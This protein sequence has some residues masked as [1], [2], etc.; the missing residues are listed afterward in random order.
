MRWNLPEE[1][2][3]DRELGARRVVDHATLSREIGSADEAVARV[4]ECKAE[5]NK[6]YYDVEGPD[7][8]E[9]VDLVVVRLLESIGIDLFPF[10]LP[11][12][13]RGAGRSR[14]F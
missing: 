1:D 6:A 8:T 9:L 10:P 5:Y 11:G 4:R 13:G 2:R 12:G 3:S 14:C 7:L